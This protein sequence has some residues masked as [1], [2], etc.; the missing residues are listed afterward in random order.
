[1]AR[2]DPHEACQMDTVLSISS[3]SRLTALAGDEGY[4]TGALAVYLPQNVGLGLGW[5][6]YSPIVAGCR[7]DS[8]PLRSFKGMEG[9]MCRYNRKITTF[10]YCHRRSI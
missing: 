8:V 1:M 6:R 9:C 7:K 10:V 4:K 2:V 5:G 3:W